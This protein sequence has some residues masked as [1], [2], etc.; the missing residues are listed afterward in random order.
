M[1]TD[2]FFLF[3]FCKLFYRNDELPPKAQ[4]VNNP[5]ANA[6]DTGDVSLIPE[7]GRC[8]GGGNGN[9]LQYSCLKNPLNRG[10]CQTTVHGVAKSQ[11]RR[12]TAP[13]FFSITLKENPTRQSQPIAPPLPASG[14]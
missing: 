2:S 6:G 9:L 5:S 4:Q 1:W 11:T 12:S 10:G 8:P 14:N 3:F 13:L 7:S